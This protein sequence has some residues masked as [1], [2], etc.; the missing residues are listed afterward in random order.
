MPRRIHVLPDTLANQI[1][2]GEVVERPASVVK[3]LVE[4]AL[5]ARATR[6]AV[7][8]RNGGKT[9]IR[10]ADDG[11]GMGREDA[12][13][14]LDR[15]ATSKIAAPEDLHSIRSFGFRGEALPSIAS[16]SRLTLESAER[17][18][19][20]TRVRMTAGRMLGVEEC[21]RQSG[22]TVEVRNLF[23]NVPAR[24]KFLRGAGVETRAISDVLVS[25]ALANL[26]TSILFESNDRTLLELPTAPDLVSRVAALW[27]DDTAGRFLPLEGSGAGITIAGLIERPDATSSGPRRVHLFVGGRPFRDRA[28]VTAAERAYRTTVPHGA[29]PS[30]LLY[31][32]AD[33]GLVDVNVHPAKAEVR[34]RDLAAVEAAVEIAVREALAGA[35][36]S[37]TFDR[38]PALPQLR[39]PV[40]APP[41]VGAAAPAGQLA[42][43]VPAPEPGGSRDNGVSPADGSGVSSAGAAA[44]ADQ[45]AG[46]DAP[47]VSA[48]SIGVATDTVNRPQLW[49]IHDTYILAETRS[50]LIIIDQ[51]SAHERIMFERIMG[52]FSAEGATSQRLLFPLTLRLSP[53]EFSVVE[54]NAELFARAGYEIEPFGGRT[55]IVHAAPNPHPY[56]DAERCLREMLT[57]LIAGS[58]LTR[59]ARNQHERIAM[60][61]ACKSAIKAGQRLSAR[62]MDELFDR[63]FAT[64]L[65]YHDVHGRPTIVRL[66]R[67]ELERRFGRHG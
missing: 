41:H 2:A 31:L 15:H 58:D 4:N 66:S 54:N 65:P 49:Q 64:E 7:S 59:A 12:L 60:I 29:R 33:P 55:V 23:M 63:L 39:R 36:S 27:G 44:A 10:V 50:G 43:F 25:L 22:T 16:V 67:E 34:F 57:E 47:A 21:A 56:F 45:V 35:A 3:E 32:Q 52:G 38:R 53:A 24:S 62:E 14:A 17:G 30:L 40:P 18:S 46:G 1:A 5:D 19:V 37:A 28:I 8:I 26:S 42:F 6:I 61:F 9:E 11:H 20:G 48:R 13:L 51:H